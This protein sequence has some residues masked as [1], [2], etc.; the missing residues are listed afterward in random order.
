MLDD[1]TLDEVQTD[2]NA[3]KLHL[4]SNILDVEG[5]NLVDLLDKIIKN[6]GIHHFLAVSHNRDFNGGSGRLKEV[7]NM[8]TD[9]Q[10]SNL[11]TIKNHKIGIFEIF[12][13]N[14]KP[15]I[16]FHLSFEV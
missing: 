6:K 14:D 3:V 7:C 1:I 12:K 16:C 2:D 10:Y 11:S 13:A 8:F 4:F 5:F 15:A 9:K